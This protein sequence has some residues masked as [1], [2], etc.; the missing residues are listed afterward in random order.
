[1]KKKFLSFALALVMCLGLTACGGG[2]AKAATIHLRKTEGTV[3]VSDNEGRGVELRENLGLYSGY[4]VDTNSKSYAWIDL[5]DVKLVKMDQDS[6]IAIAK[7]EKKLEIEVKSGSLFYNVTQPLAD[8]ETMTIRTST[9]AVGIRGTCGWVTQDAAALLEGTVEVTAGEQSVTISAA[10]MAFLT[11][12]GM[13]E[14][15]QLYIEDV[16]A[17]VAAEIGDQFPLEPTP[18]YSEANGLS[19]TK[20]KSYTTPTYVYFRDPSSGEPTLIGGL[21]ITDVV[22]STYTIGDI[23]VSEPDADGMIQMTLPYHFDFTATI[24]QED[25]YAEVEGDG[26][27]YPACQYKLFSLF[28]YY[29]GTVY[30]A[31]HLSDDNPD[32]TNSFEITYKDVTY[33][34]SYTLSQTTSDSL[35]DWDIDMGNGTAECQDAWSIDVIYTISMPKDYD[36]LCLSLYLPGKTEYKEPQKELSET[37]TLLEDLDEGE[38]INDYALIRV[39]DLM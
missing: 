32:M 15:R 39:S 27:F 13:L 12:D 2:G 4:G 34:V 30:P 14:V 18:S 28:D 21:S 29:T 8:D 22:D 31:K 24:T 7:E 33:P 17:F 19:F 9:M 10:E 37:T 23:S 3:D 25:I 20:E 1:M 5:D 35:S 6:E 38:T 11:E 36:G 26:R 16:P